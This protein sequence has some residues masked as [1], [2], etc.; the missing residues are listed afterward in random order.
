MLRYY[1]PN[2]TPS[3]HDLGEII[4]YLA[5]IGIIAMLIYSRNPEGRP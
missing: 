4:F 3:V 5:I 1:S 2:P